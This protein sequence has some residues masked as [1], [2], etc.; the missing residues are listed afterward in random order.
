[1][2]PDRGDGFLTTVEAARLVGVD[3]ST[4]SKW[5]KRGNIEP[6]GLDERKRPLY[7]R[8]TVM[9]AELEVRQ[10]GL[11]TSG[12]DPRRLRKTRVAA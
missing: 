12:I 6:D 11:D 2:L 5:R 7:R 10:H 3:P 8:E 1:M 4:I 9:V